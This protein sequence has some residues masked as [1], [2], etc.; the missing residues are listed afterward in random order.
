MFH[1]CY[2][3]IKQTVFN[4]ANNAIIMYIFHTVF[5]QMNTAE[6]YIYLIVFICTCILMHSNYFYLFAFFW[7]IYESKYIVYV[8]LKHFNHIIT[9]KIFSNLLHFQYVWTHLMNSFVL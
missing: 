6:N 1:S 2:K 7:L 8:L 4:I 5:H 3:Y 9:S